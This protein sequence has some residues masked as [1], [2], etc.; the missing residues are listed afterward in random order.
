MAITLG[1]VALTVLKLAGLAVVGLMGLTQVPELRY[2]FGSRQPAVVAG[3]ADLVPG[4]VAGPTFAAVHGTPDF[5]RAFVY[6]RYGLDHTYF[7]VEPYGLRLVVRTYG[8]VSDEW[9]EL[10]R[11]LGRLQP[12]AQQPFSYRI[13]EI[14]REQMGVEIPEDAYFLAL[15]DVP[16]P[17]GWQVGALVLS[18]VLWL[19][20]A[21][22]FF[23]W[24]PRHRRGTPPPPP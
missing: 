23:L 12:F 4:R 10:R 13:R 2:D 22:G 7:T 19:G 9:H 15:D 8:T 5:T 14:Y 3:P 1:R 20:M 21:Y 16:R 17:S 24:R 6:R 18:A 11:F